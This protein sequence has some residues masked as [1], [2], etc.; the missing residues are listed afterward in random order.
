MFGPFSHTF[1]IDHDYIRSLPELKDILDD[2]CFISWWNN[3][4]NIRNSLVKGV[5]QINRTIEI[6]LFRLFLAV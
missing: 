2:F 1:C 5:I 4:A 3:F 6:T